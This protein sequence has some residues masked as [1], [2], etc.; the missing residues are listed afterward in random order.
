V[1]LNFA[2]IDL[3]FAL[4][5]IAAAL[6]GAIRGF[7][8]EIGMMAAL[9]VGLGGALLFTK[10]LARLLAQYF[11]ESLWNQII[12]FLVIFLLIYILVKLLESLLRGLIDRLSLER[13]DR[14]LGLFLGLGEGVLLV[15]IILFLL[16]WQPFFEVDQLLGSSVFAQL[17][18]PLLPSPDRIF[19]TQH[20]LKNV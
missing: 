16:N 8:T 4:L 13:L 14:A 1:E 15:G 9:I 7:V 2:V 11:G 10:S 3:V 19:G 6:R 12:A 17:L 5:I 20:F 18:F